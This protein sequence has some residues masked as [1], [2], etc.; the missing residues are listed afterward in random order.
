MSHLGEAAGKLS[1]RSQEWIQTALFQLMEKKPYSLISITEIADK[2]GLARQTVYRNFQ[3]KDEILLNYLTRLMSGVWKHTD[4]GQPYTEAMFVLLFRTWRDSIPPSLILNIKGRDRKIRQ[5]IFRSICD[6]HDELF[7]GGSRRGGDT[8]S[9][10]YRLY[11][12]K[13]FSALLHMMLIEWTLQE[14]HLSPEE[15]GQVVS[16]LSASMRK[17][18]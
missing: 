17:F 10:I 8:P 2:A 7:I 12:Q 11:G 15:I 16:E 13:S 18:L 1:L 9:E 5:L 4:G 6:C 3:D 14:F